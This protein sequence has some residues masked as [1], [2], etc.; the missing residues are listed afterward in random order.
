[1]T[2]LG[3]WVPA[4][5]FFLQ[6]S[7]DSKVRDDALPQPPVAKVEAKELEI[8]GH[9]RQDPYFWL[10]DREDPKVIAYLN[11][12]NHYTEAMTSHTS[13][14]QEQLFNEIKGRIKQ[15]DES[16]PY[17][18]DDYYYYSRTVEGQQYS[19]LCRKKAS[20]EAAEEIILDE[21]VLAEGHDFLS[22]RGAKTS[23]DHNILSYAVDTRGRRI[24]TIHFKDLN[25]GDL[26]ADVLPETTGSLQWAMDGRTVFYTRQDQQTL[27]SHQIWRHRLGTPAEEDAL[28]YE[29][30]DDTF[31]VSLMR[32][33]SRRFLLIE[34]S[35]TLRT[36]YRYLDASTPLA[37]WQ[38]F[39]PREGEHEYHVDHHGEHWLIRS[40]ENAANFRLLVAP[41]AKTAKEHWQEIVPHRDDVYLRD[42]EVFQDFLVL[43]ERRDGLMRFRVRPF[44]ASLEGHDVDFGEP[45]YSA[46]V[47]YNPEM[48]S[49][50]VRY[51]YTSLTT[52]NS[53]VDYH[54]IAR[55]KV[56]RKETEVLGGFNKENYVTERLYAPA[57][58]GE[59]VPISLVY[60]KGA[61]KNGQNPLLLYGYGSYGYTI[62]ASFRS[63]RLS[64]I[65]R[66]FV[67]AI[68]HI[69]GS[70]VYGRRWYEDGKLFHKMN[71]F[72]DF[73]DAGEFL[74]REK[75][76]APDRL[77]A[78]GGSAGGLLMGAVINL[79]PDLFHGVLAAVPFVDVVTTMLD[80]SIPLTTSEYDE[81]GNPNVKEYYDYML[82][83]S[84]YDNVEAK[85]YPNLLVTT[86]LHDSQVQYWEPAKWVAKLR[87]TKTDGCQLLLKTNMD[88]GHGGASGRYDRYRETAFEYAFLL[89]HA[90][91]I[92]P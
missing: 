80:D 7:G 72:T 24:Y 85:A 50:V 68:A 57:R 17:R 37:E 90:G 20:L 84:P 65:D 19:I 79:R 27:R 2:T 6:L 55:E 83:Y 70:Q 13:D 51:H 73:I 31:S 66:G 30:A 69:R 36:E 26:L 91:K 23:P 5:C 89:D 9:T 39:L 18:L 28:V 29:E 62:D 14:L 41:L 81:W 77:F 38:M 61:D 43:S 44:D 42:L 78:Q 33:K 54:M 48:N 22:V 92:D 74:V 64:L 53:V 16:V 49:K 56:V 67:F 87:A 34:S 46:S 60:R 25:S 75:Y 11:Q 8:H 4:A 40:N 82:S 32:T 15:T 88:A 12:E 1:M 71:T 86:G 45:A 47:A 21:N 10:N 59:K 58:D 3:V 63:S 35:Q 52:P 76:T